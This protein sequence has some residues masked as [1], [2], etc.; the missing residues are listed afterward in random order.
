[1]KRPSVK[2]LFQFPSRTRQD[3]EADATAELDLH[4]QMRIERLRGLGAT[5]AEARAQALRE[6]GNP[7]AAFD[8]SVRHEHRIERR[9]CAARLVDDCLVDL[10]LGVRLLLRS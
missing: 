5:E 8:E 4:L 10:K 7:R 2:R 6:F 3:I 9:R 1:M